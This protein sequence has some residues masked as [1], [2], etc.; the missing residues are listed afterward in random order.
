[1]SRAPAPDRPDRD[2]A[3]EDVAGWQHEHAIDHADFLDALFDPDDPFHEVATRAV[4]ADD[5]EED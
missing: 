5:A 2:V 1:M 4:A 3:K